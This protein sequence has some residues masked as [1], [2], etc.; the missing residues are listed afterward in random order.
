MT[1]G[2]C[3]LGEHSNETCKIVPVPMTLISLSVHQRFARLYPRQVPCRAG[4]SYC[5]VN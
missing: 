1:S 5:T 4:F 3:Y 2:T